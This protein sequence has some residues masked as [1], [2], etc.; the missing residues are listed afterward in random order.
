MTDRRRAR[1]RWATIATAV[2]AAAAVGAGCGDDEK[3]DTTATQAEKGNFTGAPVTIYNIAP[4]KTQVT[5]LSDVQAT[6]RAAARALNADDGIGGHEVVVK[7]CNDVDANAELACARRAIRDKAI[8]F[9]GSANVLNPAAALGELRKAKIAS[10]APLA[11][12]QVEYG[13]PIN[14]PLYTTSFGLLACPQMITQATGAK[15]VD[16]ITADL[17]IQKE[18]LKTIGAVTA[19]QK[20]KYGG[21]VAVP[22]TQSDL[23]SAVKQLDGEAVIDILGPPVQSS[24]FGAIRSLGEDFKAYCTAPS[25]HTYDILKQL[26]PAAE[27]FYIAAGLPPT[28][29]EAAK[30]EPLIARFR[31]E[32]DAAAKAG[33]EDAG[34]DKLKKPGD[35]FNAW[36]GM[37]VL[38][39]VAGDVKGELTSATLLSALN[40]AKIDL[41]TVTPPLDFSKPVPAKGLERLFNPVVNLY[42]YDPGKSDYVATD[43]KPVN[44]LEI[45][46]ALA[47]A[48]G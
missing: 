13:S 20:I 12:T 42:K 17:P 33:D 34:V 5:D 8:A 35:S 44:V 21:G 40:K 19:V 6:I 7:F 24:L 29:E 45:F 26:G 23:S 3:Q 4:I 32:I 31:E 9:V 11:L 14:F 36:L 22:L 41:G 2:L 1:R 39:Q 38:D 46:G 28:T 43:S 27:K 18:L 30:D 10:V 15:S 47:K 16:V 37:Q 25:T 48:Q